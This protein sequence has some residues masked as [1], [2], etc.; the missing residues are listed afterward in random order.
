MKT[1]KKLF[2]KNNRYNSES[3]FLQ[4]RIDLCAYSP[5]LSLICRKFY[6]RRAGQWCTRDSRNCCCV[7]EWL[8]LADRDSMA[9]KMGMTFLYL[10]CLWERDDTWRCHSVGQAGLWGIYAYC[11]TYTFS[12]AGVEFHC[13]NNFWNKYDHKQE[14]NCR[15]ML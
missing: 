2:C 12:K 4:N 14:E 13:N 6:L 15:E 7:K 1:I 10:S 9:R 8:E 5:V 11:K 3:E